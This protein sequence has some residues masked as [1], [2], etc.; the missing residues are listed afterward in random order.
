MPQ[1]LRLMLV[2][3]GTTVLES[4]IALE[5]TP[6]LASWAWYGGALQQWHIAFLLLTDVHFYAPPRGEDT[7]RVWKCL[8][9]VFETDPRES[10][11]AKSRKILA[12]L[13]VRTGVYTRMRRMRVPKVQLRKVE[14]NPGVY[15][16]PDGTAKEGRKHSSTSPPGPQLPHGSEEMDFTLGSCSPPNASSAANPNQRPPRPPAI[17]KAPFPVAR[18]NGQFGDVPSDDWTFD[19]EAE[20]YGPVM[21]GA[22]A[23]V[24]APAP[25]PP[26]SQYSFPTVPLPIM[27]PQP[28]MPEIDWVSIFLMMWRSMGRVGANDFCCRMLSTCCFRQGGNA[29]FGFDGYGIEVNSPTDVGSFRQPC[30]C[31]MPAWWCL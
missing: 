10:Q 3:A 15:M 30:S 17:G 28:M 27:P 2:A 24:G 7:D 25:V 26:Q 6:S 22:V 23:A 21:T 1:R 13:T 20:M 5:T 29:G 14:E 18:G 12:E 4:A 11:E 19:R 9:Y 16:A 31:S 8:D